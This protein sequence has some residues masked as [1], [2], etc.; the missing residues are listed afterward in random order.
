[1]FLNL[2][3]FFL[4]AGNR[5]LNMKE[6]NKFWPLLYLYRVFPVSN[7][8]ISERNVGLKGVILIKAFPR[9]RDV[10]LLS[11][12]TLQCFEILAIFE[13][14]LL[15]MKRQRTMLK[16]LQYHPRIT[17]KHPFFKIIIISRTISLILTCKAHYYIFHEHTYNWEKY[18]SMF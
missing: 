18:F 6:P 11:K 16:N 15:Q 12:Q 3:L 17:K 10:P 9:S 4:T 14:C 2:S 1:M 7:Q 13:T 5:V 8:E